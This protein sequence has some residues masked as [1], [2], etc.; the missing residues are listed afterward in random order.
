MRAVIMRC[1]GGPIR[2]SVLARRLYVC[3]SYGEVS[4][5]RHLLGA[6]S[7]KNALRQGLAI[8]KHSFNGG[9]SS[10]VER[11]PLLA[12]RELSLDVQGLERSRQSWYF[13]RPSPHLKKR[14]QTTGQLSGP[15]P[16]YCRYWK[17]LRASAHSRCPLYRDNWLIAAGTRNTIQVCC[18]T[19]Y[20]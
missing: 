6:C 3:S 14:R 18:R 11:A 2:F 12:C 1:K 19:R 16:F 13:Q 20:R 4:V 5:H 15:G 17:T 8:V 7:H 10:T 9:S